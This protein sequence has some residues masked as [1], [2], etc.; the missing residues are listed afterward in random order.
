MILT[1]IIIR[2]GKIALQSG[3]HQNLLHANSR[4]CDMKNHF[5]LLSHNDVNHS[6][7]CRSS[8]FGLK[9]P[10]ILNGKTFKME[11]S[12]RRNRNDAAALYGLGFVGAFIYFIQTAAGFWIGVLGFFKALFWPAFLVY[13]LLEFLKK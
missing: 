6:R 12:G 4:S 13:Y 10:F 9:E 1:M 8:W 5:A 2:T 3:T 11:T 7:R